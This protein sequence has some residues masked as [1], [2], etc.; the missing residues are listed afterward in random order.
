[1]RFHHQGN[2]VGVLF[3]KPVIVSLQLAELRTARPSTGGAEKENDH[4]AL[5]PIIAQTD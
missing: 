2:D 3:L 1:L 5:I 4:L